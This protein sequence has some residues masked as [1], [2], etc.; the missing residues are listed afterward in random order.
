MEAAING[1]PALAV[2]LA[3][4]DPNS[5]FGPAAEVA[6]AVARTVRVCGLP[7]GVFLNV[8]VPPRP[9]AAR[10]EVRLTRLGRRVYRD[11]LLRREDPRGRPYYW[12]GGDPPTGEPDPDTDIWALEH[13]LVSITPV[14]MDMTAY[15]LLEEKDEWRCRLLK[16]LSREPG[17]ER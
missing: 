13:E 6:A 14:H 11:V 3:S 4:Y 17:G 15:S 9:D 12:I 2:S 8:N 5:D 7:A 1:L 16:E 10:R